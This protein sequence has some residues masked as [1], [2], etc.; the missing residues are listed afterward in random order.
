MRTNIVI[1]DRLVKEG[2]MIT[3]FKTKKQ[4]VNYAIQ[5]LIN[6]KKR[7]TILDLEGRLHWED[8]LNKM[9]GSHCEDIG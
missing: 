5:E 1:D 7:K 4:L 9:R 6:R 2:L 8:D 3:G